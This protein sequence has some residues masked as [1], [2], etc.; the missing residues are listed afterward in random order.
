MPDSPLRHH[1]RSIGIQKFRERRREGEGKGDHHI[2]RLGVSPV[3]LQSLASSGIVGG[4]VARA[5][6]G[7]GL[8]ETS[9]ELGVE[10]GPGRGCRPA[11]VARK[12]A[13]AGCVSGRRMVRWMVRWRRRCHGRRD[14]G[15]KGNHRSLHDGRVRWRWGRGGGGGGGKEDQA[16]RL[17]D[18][19]REKEIFHDQLPMEWERQEKM[20]ITSNWSGSAKVEGFYGTS[21]R[22]VPRKPRPTTAK[23]AGSR[24]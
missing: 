16:I 23:N 9:T 20:S 19:D 3:V 22:T 6:D 17:K 13:A 1:G 8:D 7:D 18:G 10:V 21:S 5:A 4:I 24:I 2:L 11:E 14:Q 15:R 12:T